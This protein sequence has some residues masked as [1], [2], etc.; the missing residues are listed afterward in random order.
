[1]KLST[2]VEVG[3]SIEYVITLPPGSEGEDSVGLHCLGKVLRSSASTGKHEAAHPFS[4]AATLERYEF[5]RLR[6][7]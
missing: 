3:E 7:A 6:S 2:K 1:M 5:V 4:V